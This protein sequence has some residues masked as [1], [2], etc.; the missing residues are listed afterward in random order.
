MYSGLF[1]ALTEE[2]FGAIGVC[3]RC[4]ELLVQVG[5]HKPPGGVLAEVARSMCSLLL[6]R[7]VLRYLGAY[8]K[9]G[10]LNWQ[11]RKRHININKFF[12]GDCPG[13]GGGVTRPGGQGSPDWWPGVKS[14]CAVCGTQGT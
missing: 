6:A 1:L 7:G 13:G 3:Q 4:L 12:F 11:E 10:P 5:C 8:A 9:S 14:L 2:P